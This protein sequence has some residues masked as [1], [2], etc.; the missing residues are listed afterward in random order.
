MTDDD[1][2]ALMFDRCFAVHAPG[3]A[4]VAEEAAHRP[5]LDALFVAGSPLRGVLPDPIVLHQ[6]AMRETAYRADYP[7]AMRRVVLADSAPIGRIVVDWESDG[8]AMLIDIAVLPEKQGEGVGIAMLRAYLDVVDR[9]GQR[10]MLQ[11]MRDNSALALYTRLGFA[12]VEAQDFA[13]YIDMV[14]QPRGGD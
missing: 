14:R 4:A 8:A 7:A 13:P 12:Q 6:A 2:A 10:A 11:V 5:F 3:L 9:R 1:D